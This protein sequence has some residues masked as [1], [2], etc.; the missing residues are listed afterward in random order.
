VCVCVC[1]NFNNIV[2]EKYLFND[3]INCYI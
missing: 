1:F 2:Y 3:V